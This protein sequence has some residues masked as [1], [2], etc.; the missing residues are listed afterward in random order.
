MDTVGSETSNRAQKDLG[1]VGDEQSGLKG[2]G[3]VGDE[4]L[5]SRG[6]DGGGR[7][8]AGLKRT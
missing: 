1:R 8:A 3:W 6:H 7:Q 4:R 2:H 5:G